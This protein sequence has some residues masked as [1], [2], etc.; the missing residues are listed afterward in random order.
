MRFIF[1]LI[2]TLV[3][4]SCNDNSIDNPNCQFLLDLSI[5]EV[6]N[7]NLPQYSQL[8]FAGNS[9]YLPNAGNGGIIVASTGVDYY[10]WDA[11]DPNRIPS[12]CSVL[13]NS[14]LT[15]TSSCADQNEYSLVTGQALGDGNLPC[16]LQFYRVQVNGNTLLISN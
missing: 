10:A 1:L 8:Q 7:L 11:A 15:A 16:T 6:V 9:V 14:G 2:A 3:L 12:A 5:N 13:V 4:T